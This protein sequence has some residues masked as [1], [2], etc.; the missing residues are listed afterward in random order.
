MTFYERE[1]RKIIGGKYPDATYV[2][3]ACYVRLSDTNRAKIQF[4]TG[5]V[6]DQY[7]A[8]RVT[9]LNCSEGQVDVLLLRFSDLLGIKHTSNPNFRNGIN[10]HI[11]DCD[12]RVDWYVY[13]PNQHDY[14]VLSDA[15]SDYLDVFKDK[16]GGI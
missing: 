12:G 1:L 4:V 10:P 6:A 5:I 13:Y 15:V 14:E 8:I 9:I 3:R 7:N 16:G 2:G 11:W